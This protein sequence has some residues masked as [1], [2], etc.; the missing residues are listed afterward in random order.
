MINVHKL[1]P[2][3]RATLE[4]LFS[5]NQKSLI[6]TMDNFLRNKYETVVR[7]KKFLY[8]YTLFLEC[9]I[10]AFG[11]FVYGTNSISHCFC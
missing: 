2:N 5:L 6:H 3:D 11:N 10:I 8:P 9:R 1:K 4:G 7:N